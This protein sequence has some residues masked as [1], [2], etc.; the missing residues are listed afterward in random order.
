MQQAHRFTDTIES[1]FDSH[2]GDEERKAAL[3]NYMLKF[4]FVG[5]KIYTLAWKDSKNKQELQ[6]DYLATRVSNSEF[7]RHVHHRMLPRISKIFHYIQPKKSFKL[8]TI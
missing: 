1:L 6:R 7:L 4:K 8:A 3:I 2:G 5:Y